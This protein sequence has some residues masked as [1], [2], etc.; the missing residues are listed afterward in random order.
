ML[1]LSEHDRNCR[2]TED[3]RLLTFD[4]REEKKSSSRL[5]LILNDSSKEIHLTVFIDYFGL[6]SFF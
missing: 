3:M 2:K 1:E 5:E 6:L 4:Q